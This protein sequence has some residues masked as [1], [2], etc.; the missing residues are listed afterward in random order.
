MQPYQN[1]SGKSNIDAYEIG[2]DF[3]KVSFSNGTTYTY[4]YDSA[5]QEVVDQ[6]KEL[7]A[8]GSGLNGFINKYAKGFYGDY[9]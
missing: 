3:I 2:E 1:N 9:E 5:G 6:M 7:A 8:S 4:T